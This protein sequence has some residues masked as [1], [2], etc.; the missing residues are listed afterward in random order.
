MARRAKRRWRRILVPVGLLAFAWAVGLFAFVNEIPLVAEIRDDSL[1]TD[2]IVVLTGGRG[3]VELGTALLAG[4]AARTML[5]SGVGP[6]V[7][8]RDLIP[9]SRLNPATLDCC[10]TL[11]KVARNTRENAVEAAG[12]VA[13]NNVASLRLVTADFHMPRSLL[14]FHSRLPDTVIVADPVKSENVR[15]S[16]WWRWPGTAFLLA[17]EYNKYLAARARVFVAQLADRS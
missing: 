8:P 14:E 17:G 10:V 13:A 15:L 12:W 2:A 11:G 6:N 4:S 16:N 3:R 5:I 9:D 7:A 1:R